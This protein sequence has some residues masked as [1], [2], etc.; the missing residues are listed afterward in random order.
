MFLNAQKV[1]DVMASCWE[2]QPEARPRFAQLEDSFSKMFEEECPDYN[3]V[4]ICRANG[5]AAEV[6]FGT[7]SEHAA[8]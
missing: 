2:S 6:A 3:D 1:Y 8:P 4:C 5:S 7:V